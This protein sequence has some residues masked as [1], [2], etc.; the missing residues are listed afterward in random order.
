MQYAVNFRE[1]SARLQQY[2]RTISK[3]R[4]RA[5]AIRWQNSTYHAIQNHGCWQGGIFTLGALETLSSLTGQQMKKKVQA[6]SAPQGCQI[7]FFDAQFHKFDF[8]RDSWRQKNCFFLNIWFFWRQLAHA[9]RLVS[10]LL[11][12]LPALLL[13]FFR[14]CLVIFSKVI[15]QPIED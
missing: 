4:N 6:A 1:V 12:I 11:N 8:F 2:T 7:C 5:M 9:I 3:F 14:Q 15:W 10:S 13:G